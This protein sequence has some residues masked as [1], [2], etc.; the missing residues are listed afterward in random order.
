[1]PHSFISPAVPDFA[2]Q[3]VEEPVDISLHNC[4][5][6]RDASRSGKASVCAN[7]RQARRSPWA[8]GRK[9]T[10]CRRFH[11]KG[12]CKFGELCTFSHNLDA[13]AE[14]ASLS[15]NGDDSHGTEDNLSSFAFSVDLFPPLVE[16]AA[17]EEHFGSEGVE[18]VRD[19]LDFTFA[20][21]RRQ[22]SLHADINNDSDFDAGVLSATDNQLSSQCA[23]AARC[24]P[25]GAYSSQSSQD[26]ETGAEAEEPNVDGRSRPQIDD[27]AYMVEETKVKVDSV[28]KSAT[29]CV[30][31]LVLERGHIKACTFSLSGCRDGAKC[32]N[33]HLT[34]TEPC[35]IMQ[36]IVRI[37]GCH[38]GH[39]QLSSA[40]SIGNSF[41]R[42]VHKHDF[43]LYL[44]AK[45]CISSALN[46]AAPS[47]LSTDSEGSVQP[48]ARAACSR[49]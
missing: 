2:R 49:P 20:A 3:A 44:K 23:E 16:A 25:D 27:C 8:S 34:S 9:A 33:S 28:L 22:A 26:E 17:T 1:M 39:F 24:I 45:K 36:E 38:A 43:E 18:Y 12:V 40:D 31:P 30:L 47:Q 29:D 11:R 48:V 7:H 5:P 10:I 37:R 15:D 21:W 32:R 19:V 46:T 13:G 6:S 41:C 42:T 35:A 4:L 14:E